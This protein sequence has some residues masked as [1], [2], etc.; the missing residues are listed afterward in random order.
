MAEATQNELRVYGLRRMPYGEAL[1]MQLRLRDECIRTG[2]HAQCLMLVEHP[3]VITIGRSGDEG[4]LLFERHKRAGRGV[5][6]V[7]CSRGG[8]ITY[9]GPGQMVAYPIVHLGSRGRDL[10]RYLRDLEQWVVRLCR[11]YSVEA[12]ADGPQTGVWVGERKIASIGIACRRWVTYHGVAL[13][14]ST[15][16]ADF[17]LIVPCGL[18]GVTMTSIEREAGHAPPLEDV[19]RRAAAM[20]AQDFGL[21]LLNVPDEELTTA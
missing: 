19:S 21:E 11:S 14:V 3:P 2:G 6:V 4:D 7:E 8:R 12:H 5:E 1:R 9:H 20:F 17:D 15:D 13:N 10:H 16:L 18:Q